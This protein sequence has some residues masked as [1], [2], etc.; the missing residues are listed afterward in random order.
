MLLI[1]HQRFLMTLSRKIIIFEPTLQT[2]NKF[3]FMKGT[4]GK[5]LF[6]NEITITFAVPLNS[7]ANVKLF[8]SK[9]HLF[10]N[11]RNCRYI[12]CFEWN[13]N[14]CKSSVLFLH[15]H[16][17]GCLKSIFGQRNSIWIKG[18][19]CAHG[20]MAEIKR[21]G[22]EFLWQSGCVINIKKNKLNLWLTAPKG[23]TPVN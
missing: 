9:R 17:N 1:V 10:L 21:E 3:F 23:A 2:T 13:Y 11:E 5:F 16:I 18:V 12:S 20:Q 22:V 7:F 15:S 4:T 6:F 19:Q 8:R 14:K